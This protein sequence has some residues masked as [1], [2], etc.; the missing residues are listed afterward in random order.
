MAKK[1]MSFAEKAAKHKLHK[2]WKTVKYVKSERSQKTG[3]WRFNESFI[4]LATNENLDQ[5]LTRMEKEVKALAEEM[6]TI[7]SSSTEKEQK[8][9][10]KSQDAEA[11]DVEITEEK[12]T[13]EKVEPT[14]KVEA[15][16]SEVEQAAQKA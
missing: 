1:Q 14:A 13:E 2:D 9:E 7:E 16:E 6:A 12:K 5:A 11:L 3:S 4:Q 10:I 8:K 15:K